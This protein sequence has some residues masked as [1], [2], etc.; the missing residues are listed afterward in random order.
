MGQLR[1][2]CMT[3]TMLRQG[4]SSIADELEV[5]LPSLEFAEYCA[6]NANSYDQLVTLQKDFVDVLDHVLKNPSFPTDKLFTLC[7]IDNSFQLAVRLIKRRKSE[8][9]NEK[10]QKYLF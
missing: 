7:E 10:S 4:Y 3:D 1:F 6:H 2:D 5:I 9:D 8:C